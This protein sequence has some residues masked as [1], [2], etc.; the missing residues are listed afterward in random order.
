M[1]GFAR[2]QEPAVGRDDIGAEQIVCG[3]PELAADPAEPAAER[4]PGDP[5]GRVDAGRGD[6]PECLRLTVEF[7]ERDARF[8]PRRARKGIDPD[9]FHQ[10]Q[11]DHHAAVAD[12]AAGDVVAT[13]ADRNQ[14]ALVAGEI[15]RRRDV[16]CAGTAHD[17]GRPPVDHRVPDG[18]RGVV[19]VVP[20]AQHGAADTGLQHIDRFLRQ[21][22]RRSRQR[23]QIE[24]H[25]STPPL[26]GEK[27]AALR[28][29]TT[30]QTESRNQI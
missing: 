30:S 11:I 9:R 1:L 25:R 24:C 14:R 4:Q 16:G 26:L 5:R 6:E 7:A 28:S 21:G 10:A 23:R 13:A 20:A 8:D 27:I 29:K 3:Q 22:G 15:H 19:A 17:D 12:R 18:A 2:M